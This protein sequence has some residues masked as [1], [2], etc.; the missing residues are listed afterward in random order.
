[1][2]AGSTG[3]G[4]HGSWGRDGRQSRGPSL[5]AGRGMARAAC[6]ACLLQA[7]GMGAV[8]GRERGVGAG[9]VGVRRARAREW[10]P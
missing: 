9:A 6:E 8:S 10:P 4:G 7:R 5:R 1:M 3:V 2:G